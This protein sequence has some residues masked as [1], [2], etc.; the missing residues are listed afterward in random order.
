MEE[1]NTQ[2]TTNQVQYTADQLLNNDDFLQ[3]EL[4]PTKENH[5]QWEELAHI[6]KNTAKEMEKARRIL[7]TI[8]RKAHQPHLSPSEKKELWE[9]I[10]RV[11]KTYTYRRMVYF[12][13]AVSV[14]AAIALLFIL[15]FTPKEEETVDY[16]V[17]IESAQQ[18]QDHSGNIQLVLS[19][20]QQFHLEGKESAIEYEEEGSIRVNSEKIALKEGAEQ[21]LVHNT[22]IVPV[23]KRTF[24]TLSDGTKMWVNSDSRI[25]YPNR[26]TGNTR[27][28]F[29]EGEAFLDVA[30]NN[31]TPFIV[32]THELTIKVLGTRF[33]I[34]S[35]PDEPTTEV[36]LVNGQVEVK[37]KESSEATSK[38]LFP[39]DLY[40]Y[41]NATGEIRVTKTD[42]TDYI[43]WR[44]GYYL[45]K[46]QPLDI[47]LK[48][49]ARYYGIQI[50]WDA[51]VSGLLCSG[52]LDLL[53]DPAE[54]FTLL[55][56]AAPIIVEER[57]GEY[58]VK[59]K[60]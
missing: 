2:Q 20:K 35:F 8:R 39:D 54:M 30:R 6:D 19:N 60:P 12:T 15:R 51:K 27:E 32:K 28:I 43:A 50:K 17:L 56:K 7:Q 16:L 10:H 59:V 52:K 25:I 4:H 23:G 18:L 22:L 1:K 26:F 38:T 31:K 55:R 33:N 37:A 9:R 36:V 11:N 34:I 5:R 40:R 21:M 53:D 41:N 49:I 46:S 45:Y 24:L 3:A 42:V 58:L 14:A 57:N 13:L 48:K 47:V 44:D 29:I